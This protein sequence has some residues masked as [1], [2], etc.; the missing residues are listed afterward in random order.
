MKKTLL[1]ATL[2]AAASLP[3]FGQGVVAFQN[4]DT[5]NG[6]DAPVWV[7]SVGSATGKATDGVKG[8]TYHA[9]LYGAP[10]A[11]AAT[12]SMV[13]LANPTDGQTVVSFRT[14]A[15]A[16]Y[17]NV[18][19]SAPRVVAGAAFGSTV[20]VQIR[21]WSGSAATY[22]TAA[23]TDYKGVSTPI[24]MATTTGPTDPNVPFMAGLQSFAVVV[25]EP[26]SI[27]LGLLGLGALTLFRRRK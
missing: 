11:G 23:G 13:M 27:A 7:D 20:S 17:V 12:S 24:N 2:I 3:A 25:P 18:G 4:R 16:G 6:V 15:A 9:A 19:G 8:L 1:L 10:G 26:S 21:A 5:A 14:G 22:E